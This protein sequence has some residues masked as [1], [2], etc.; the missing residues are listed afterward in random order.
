PVKAKKGG[1]GGITKVCQLSPQLDKFIGTS[2]IA[3]T[4]PG[5]RYM[6]HLS[7]SASLRPVTQVLNLT[8][9]GTYISFGTDGFECNV[10]T[11]YGSQCVCFSSRH[12]QIIRPDTES[13]ELDE[14][15]KKP[16]K[17][18]CVLLT[19]DPLPPSDALV[20]FFGDGESSLSRLV[21]RLWEYIKQN[22][23][24]DPSDISVSELITSHF[25]KTKH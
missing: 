10:P 9:R 2:Q 1:G 5:Q 17:E 21:Q 24:Q 12:K 20:K 15:D 22:E 13:D 6:A 4:E 25:I 19:P 3:R 23:L 16:K 14:N 18:G 11:F 7:E 8:L